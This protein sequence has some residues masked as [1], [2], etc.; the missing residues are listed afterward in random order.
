MAATLSRSLSRSSVSAVMRDTSSKKSSS[1]ARSRNGAV[2]LRVAAMRSP[3][4]GG[5]LDNLDA[6]AGS[7]A[8]RARGGHTLQVFER[9]DPARR[10]NSHPGADRAAHQGNVMHGR[11]VRAEAG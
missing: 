3:S 11:S 2:A 5:G 7:H 4:G 6:G 10:L 9:A 8:R 1:S